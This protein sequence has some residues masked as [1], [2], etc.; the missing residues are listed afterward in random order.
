MYY[1]NILRYRCI[2]P[3]CNL[4]LTVMQRHI[5]YWMNLNLKNRRR[6]LG[7][8]TLLFTT[9]HVHRYSRVD[10]LPYC[11]YNT[12]HPQLFRVYFQF[13]IQY[14]FIRK[15]SN[16]KDSSSCDG[17]YHQATQRRQGK[18]QL[19]RSVVKCMQQRCDRTGMRRTD[20]GHWLISWIGSDC[21]MRGLPH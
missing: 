1:Y 4:K 15:T 13:R 17:K 10:I 21:C 12:D 7:L 3:T 20:Y 9:N 18:R 14:V 16:Y 2:I 11:S 19:W 6:L 8:N 5:A